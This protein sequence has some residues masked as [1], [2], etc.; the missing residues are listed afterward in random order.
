MAAN[1]KKLV[2]A[3]LDRVM[4]GVVDSS[5]YLIGSTGTAPVAGNQTGSTMLQLLGA[6]N[7]PFTP[8]DPDRPTSTG[9][10]GSLARFLFEATE[11]PQADPTF[12]AFDATF[13]AL[14]Q[15]MITHDIGGFTFAPVQPD[16]PTYADMLFLVTRQAKSQD[17][18][19]VGASHWDNLL[20]LKANVS[21]RGSSFQERATAEEGYS[22]IGN[23]AE[24]YPWGLAFSSGNNGTTQMV[25]ARF[26]SAYRP[27][28]QRWTGD[29][30][31]DEFTLSATLANNA[32]TDIAVY[33]AGVAQTWAAADPGAGAG[34]FDVAS[35]TMTF[36]S[37][38]ADGAKIVAIYGYTP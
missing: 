4:Y 20:I 5:G 12:G 30:A 37:V 8:V 26:S 22:M 31:E 2:G 10:D 6:K 36:G 9:D 24:A 13:D 17:T 29:G 7:F 35:S 1:V 25:A 15:G 33:V 32:A 34:E 21:P 16:S 18:G 28:I 27:V 38:P 3:G 19:S 23:Y 11:L 14:I